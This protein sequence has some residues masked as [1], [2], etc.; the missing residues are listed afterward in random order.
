MQHATQSL[1]RFLLMLLLLVTGRQLHAQ[2]AFLNEIKAFK[3]QDSL[4]APPAKPILFIGSSSFRKWTEVQAAFPGYTILNRAF[5]GSTLPDVIYYADDVIFPYH[6]KEIV[7]YC[8]E[9]DAASSDTITSRTVFMRFEKLFTLIRKKLPKVPVVFVGMKPSP[10][11][12]KHQSK[13]IQA[14]LLIKNYLS[15]QPKT[16]YVDVYRL[17]LVDGKPDESLF[18]S[19]MLHMNEKGYAIWQK[20]IQPYLV[21]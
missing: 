13:I 10:S 9:N 1:T 16:G 8:G 12:M 2:D 15:K 20:A 21:K 7:I 3:K 18:L 6:P 19:D 14:N 11:R 4:Q 5:G 17:M